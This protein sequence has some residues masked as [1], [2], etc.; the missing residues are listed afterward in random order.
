MKLGDKVIFDKCYIK[1]IDYL[2][3]DGLT[4]EQQT[5]LEDNGFINNNRFITHQL[6]MTVEGIICGK[7]RTWITRKLWE[8]GTGWDGS[9]ANE[10]RVTQGEIGWLYIVANDMYKFYKVPAEYLERG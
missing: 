6:P 9:E 4:D 2:T 3:P 5:E 10:F 8:Y 7:R 1:N